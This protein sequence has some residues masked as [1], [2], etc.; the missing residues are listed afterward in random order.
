MSEKVCLKKIRIDGGTQPRAAIYENIIAD[1][2]NALLDGTILPPV[3]VFFDG[4]DY[5]LGDGFHRYHANK[6]ARL[7]EIEADVRNGTQRDAIL[8]SVGANE[9]HGLRRTNEDKRRAVLT[10]LNDEEWSKWSNRVIARQCAVS[11]GFVDKLRASLPTVGTDDDRT[12]V[13]KHG[14]VGTMNTANIGSTPKVS[15]FDPTQAREIL[16]QRDAIRSDADLFKAAK[17]A[18]YK[19]SKVR[20][21]TGTGENEWYTPQKYLDA[22]REV[23]GSVIDLDPASN[24]EAQKNVKAGKFYS[25]EDDGPEAGMERPR[26]AQSAVFPIARLHQKTCRG[27]ESR[28]RQ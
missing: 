10:L 3:V 6:K 11:P 25:K 13:D 20:G 18:G 17:E 8:Y 22:A 28:S 12:Y 21:T 16:E 24:D 26:L 27:S 9:S 7:S 5:W 15:P 19:P 23:F 2:A 4:D 1:Y 14:N